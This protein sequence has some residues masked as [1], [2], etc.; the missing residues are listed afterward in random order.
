MVLAIGSSAAPF[1]MYLEGRIFQYKTFSQEGYSSTK[2]S[3]RKNMPV[4]NVYSVEIPAQDIQPPRIFQY[5]IFSH[6]DIPVQNIQSL[7]IFQYNIFSQ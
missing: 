3:A 2:Y 5:K 7:R 1:S 6:T 4:Q